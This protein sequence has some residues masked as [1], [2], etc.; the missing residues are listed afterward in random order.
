MPTRPGDCVGYLCQLH[1]LLRVGGAHYGTSLLFMLAGG[2]WLRAGE[3]RGAYHGTML[4]LLLAG[5]GVDEGCK[6]WEEST[7]GC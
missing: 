3:G 5:K 1:S 6:D 4:L 2:V 7:W